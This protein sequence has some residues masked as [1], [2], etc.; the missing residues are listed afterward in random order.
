M[1]S[2]KYIAYYN[3]DDNLEERVVFPSASSKINTISRAIGEKGLK[4][5]IISSSNTT[6]TKS[7]SSRKVKHISDNIRLILLKGYRR[8]GKIRN[9][10][11]GLMFKL[12][13]GLYCLRN[14]KKGDTVIVYHSLNYIGLIKWLKKCKKIKLI[15]EVEEIYGDVSNS[16]ESRKIEYSLFP[17]ADAY[18]FST[19]MLNRKINTEN[20]PNV[21]INGTY[22]LAKEMNVERTDKCI[23][24]VYAGTLDK[25][26]GGAYKAVQSAEF[27]DNR[28]E[29]CIVGRGSDEEK[30]YLNEL[31]A[32]NNAVSDCKA[33]YD[34]EKRGDD[35]FRY[36]QECQIGLSTQ[37][38][39]EEY[40]NTSFPSKVLT[41]FSNGLR[42]VA[43]RCENIE[44]SDIGDMIYYYDGNDPKEIAN[45]IKSIN[46]DDTYNPKE[47]LISLKDRFGKEMFH[48]IMFLE[49]KNKN[50]KD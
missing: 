24:C 48:L 23:R 40:N 50:I 32:S 21:I 25:I 3:T 11:S 10:Y 44:T 22:D 30:S 20:K 18:I 35:F 15:L 36:L 43:G 27:L 12:S 39:E 4:V 14:I 41:Y 28:F 37:N 8:G 6:S 16:I 49:G 45:A 17:L 29:I 5:D 2:I 19:A 31:I 38:T 26:K 13:F 33:V 42:V 9:K 46:F 7:N 1:K 47:R 34:G